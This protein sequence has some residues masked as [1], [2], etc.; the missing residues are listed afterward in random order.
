MKDLCYNPPTETE[1]L[2][3]S[4][5]I[6]APSYWIQQLLGVWND[7]NSHPD[8][9]IFRHRR[10]KCPSYRNRNLRAVNSSYP[11]SKRNLIEV[12]TAQPVEESQA[13]TKER[14]PVSP[15]R[16][17]RQQKPL[18]YSETGDLYVGS[19]IRKLRAEK[20][21]SMKETAIRAEAN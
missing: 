7:Q 12:F 5:N 2:E 1:L 6:C 13:Q 19:R 4:S 10:V 21:L 8:L 20:G 16:G 15:R 11:R 3:R 9:A 17:G 14:Q 18:E